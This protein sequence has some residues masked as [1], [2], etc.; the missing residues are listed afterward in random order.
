MIQNKLISNKQFNVLDAI[1]KLESLGYTILKPDLDFSEEL[2]ILRNYNLKLT[3]K[4][5]NSDLA[6]LL[7]EDED[8][9]AI[10]KFQNK[11]KLQGKSKKEIN[12]S[13]NECFNSIIDNYENLKINGILS[14]KFL[15][16]KHGSWVF[17]KLNNLNLQAKNSYK[18]SSQYQEFLDSECSK[19]DEYLIKLREKRFK[20]IRSAK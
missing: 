11:A 20:Q 9:S 18:D 1:K 19:D 7:N 5:K 2:K 6:V 13:L 14:I 15:L 8:L 12:E 10:K 4:F 3:K 17:Q 16:S